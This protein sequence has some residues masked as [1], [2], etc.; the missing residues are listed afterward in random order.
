MCKKYINIYTDEYILKS[1]VYNV[2]NN[3][4]MTSQY[5]SLMKSYIK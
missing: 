2:G 4:S 3:I 5:K 1:G